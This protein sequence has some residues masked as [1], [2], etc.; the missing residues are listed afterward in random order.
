MLNKLLHDRFKVVETLLIRSAGGIGNDS[1]V[2]STILLFLL[3][4]RIQQVRLC[5]DLPLGRRLLLKNEAAAA[6][7]NLLLELIELV[8]QQ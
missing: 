5:L 3:V 8:L 1:L 6:R 7:L 2:V 4:A